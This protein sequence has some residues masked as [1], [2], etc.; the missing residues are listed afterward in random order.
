MNDR[1]DRASA[2]RE[3]VEIEFDVLPQLEDKA[4]E[5]GLSLFAYLVLFVS[6]DTQEIR[7]HGRVFE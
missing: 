2:G 7:R 3:K 4:R 5:K 6:E 1:A